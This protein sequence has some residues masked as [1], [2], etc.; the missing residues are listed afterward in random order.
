MTNRQARRLSYIDLS[1]PTLVLPSQI[2]G[3]KL[4]ID[5]LFRGNGIKRSW[6]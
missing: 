5:S 6:E 3:G 1:T 2:E 4:I